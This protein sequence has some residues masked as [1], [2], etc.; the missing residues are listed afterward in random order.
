MLLRIQRLDRFDIENIRV[1]WASMKAAAEEP[2]FEHSL[3]GHTVSHTADAPGNTPETLT[4]HALEAAL[5]D[6]QGTAADQSTL[7]AR[8]Q[9]LFWSSKLQVLQAYLLAAMAKD[10]S[11]MISIGPCSTSQSMQRS[12]SQQ[13]VGDPIPHMCCHGTQEHVPVRHISCEGASFCYTL[14]IVDTEPK[15]AAKIQQHW[16]LDRK[17]LDLHTQGVQ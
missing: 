9:R 2:A 17:I 16:E 10:C 13:P 4:L 6:A 3:S 14:A 15:P 12:D 7:Q 11:I 1:M 5:D 8:L